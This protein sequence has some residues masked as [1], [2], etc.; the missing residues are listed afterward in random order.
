MQLRYFAA[1]REKPSPDATAE[2]VPDRPGPSDWPST[3]A[4]TT[5]AE[6][7]PPQRTEPEPAK[8]TPIERAATWPEI[9]AKNIL[10]SIGQIFYVWN[11]ASDRIDWSANALEFFGFADPQMISTG[12]ALAQNL[13]ADSEGRPREKIFDTRP[14][15]APN[16]DQGVAFRLRYGVA[17]PSVAREKIMWIEDDGCWFADADGRPARAQGVLRKIPTPPL[18]QRNASDA[19]F[20]QLTGVLSRAALIE[21][22]ARFFADSERRRQNFGALL[23][24]VDNLFALNRSYGYDVADQ[25]IA[26]LAARLRENCREH[27]LLARYAGNKFA[28]LLENCGDAEMDAAARRLIDA[29]AETPFDTAAGPTPVALRAGGAIAPRCGRVA[30]VLFQRAEQALDLARQPGAPRFVA[31]EPS[32]AREDGRMRELKISDEI[33]AALNE[34]RIL[35]AFQPVICA[36]TGKPAFYEALARLRREDGEIATPSAFLPIAEKTGQIR[37]IDQKMLELA[38]ARLEAEPDLRLAV[39]ISGQTLHEA[40]FCGRLKALL[41]PRPDVAPR[42][43]VELTETCAILD[44]EATLDAI[45][46]IRRLG[47]RLAMDDFGAGHTSFKNL[48]RFGFDLVKIDG[49]FVQNLSHSTDDQVFVRALIGLAHHIRIPVVAEWIEDQATAELLRGW[50]VDYFQGDFF[51]PAALAADPTDR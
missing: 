5:E 20:D 46:A 44:V 2:A 14:Q 11:L 12:A 40:D 29:V 50:G 16:P 22:S 38:A 3:K 36:Q 17:N 32:L 21:Q 19:R 31:F 9:D 35:A 41:A 4:Q 18:G 48:R 25:I 39:N 47:P 1:P 7:K 43:T 45:A 34:G 23:I 30:H 8:P 42:L 37:L 10:T 15:G 27:D 6:D 51:G 26:G 49:A 24:G 13:V 33:A 28:I